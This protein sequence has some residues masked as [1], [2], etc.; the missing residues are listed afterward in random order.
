MC[1]LR[2]VRVVLFAMRVKCYVLF[3]V[4]M[5][6]GVVLVVCVSCVCVR[7]PVCL[8]L[9]VRV[10]NVCACARTVHELSVVCGVLCVVESR[11]CVLWCVAV[12]MEL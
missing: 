5:L 3:C 1:W 10:C 7:V 12:Y 4:V 2:V 9:S 8:C 11:G 6:C